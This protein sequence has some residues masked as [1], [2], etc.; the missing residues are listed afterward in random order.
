MVKRQAGHDKRER[1]KGICT[2]VRGKTVTVNLR[3]CTQQKAAVAPH[4]Q[5]VG[6]G[7]VQHVYIS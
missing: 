2:G 5:E 7:G 6:V 3:R 4:M 1:E